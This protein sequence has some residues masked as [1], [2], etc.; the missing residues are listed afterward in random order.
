MLSQQRPRSN[1][2][3]HTWS[4][5]PVMEPVTMVS[6]ASITS[7]SW[8]APSPEV[9]SLAGQQGKNS[10]RKGAAA[11]SRS[12]TASFNHLSGHW[13][14]WATSSHNFCHK[15]E[16][17]GNPRVPA[18]RKLCN[19]SHCVRILRQSTQEEPA[20]D[21]SAPNSSLSSELIVCHPGLNGDKV[22]AS[23]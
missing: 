15:G 5:P 20:S 13:I 11:S 9:A 23:S 16:I 1:W 8:L 4:P 22:E 17:V 10:L 19:F 18:S 2:I 21:F 3:R 14:N 12:S 7:D 6:K